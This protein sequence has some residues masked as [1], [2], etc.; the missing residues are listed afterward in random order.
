MMK[1]TILFFV[2]MPWASVF[3]GERLFENLPKREVGFTVMVE[4]R[5]SSD[6]ELAL[7]SGESY[8]QTEAGDEA[9][10]VRVDEVEDGAVKRVSVKLVYYYQ[11]SNDLGRLPK[12]GAAFVLERD[13]TDT[14]LVEAKDHKGQPFDDATVQHIKSN[15]FEAANWLLLER[16][17]FERMQPGKEVAVGDS[18][19]V[20][21]VILKW[22]MAGIL[23][24]D[25]TLAADKSSLSLTLR[26]LGERIVVDIAMEALL[27][28]DGFSMTLTGKGPVRYDRETLLE[29]F[30]GLEVQ[31]KGGDSGGEASISASGG[32]GRDIRT[33]SASDFKSAP[34][35]KLKEAEAK[36][37][38]EMLLPESMFSS[39][40]GEGATA[41]FQQQLPEDRYAKLLELVN[42]NLEDKV[43]HEPGVQALRLL[44]DGEEAAEMRA[45]LERPE[46]AAWI[47][48]GNEVAAEDGQGLLAFIENDAGS[49]DA[50]GQGLAIRLVAA[51]GLVDAVTNFALGLAR[52]TTLAALGFMGESMSKEQFDSMYLAQYATIR[53]QISYVLVQTAHY[54]TSNLEA[55]EFKNLVEQSES[56]LGRRVA[57]ARVLALN[58]V[59]QG[60]AQRIHEQT[61]EL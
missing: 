26:E 8:A 43:L 29:S 18:W 10:A 25:A 9:W 28:T 57:K 20:D 23:P 1:P 11:R 61:S 60:V 22:T 32:A 4:S 35:Y 5:D 54:S 37:L 7:S 17:V 52:E 46:Q 58:A 24:E 56:E 36:A 14:K 34:A 44:Y 45:F 15:V 40:T 21:P 31:I 39:L 3:A 2:L 38:Y 49:Q 6:V 42:R 51:N 55:G 50:A 48:R 53:E 12:P 59:Y 16:K 13:G 27:E 30:E 47:K 41:S 19:K 33:I